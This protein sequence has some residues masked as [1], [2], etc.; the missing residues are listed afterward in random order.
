MK[1]VLVSVAMCAYNGEKYLR[2]Q[3]DSILSQSYSPLQIIIVDDNSSDETRNILSLYSEEHSNIDIFFNDSNLGY[4]K[5]F[6][7]AISKAEGEFIAIS[8]QD[9]IWLHDKVATLVESIGDNW[10]IF[11]NSQFIDSDDRLLNESLLPFFAFRSDYRG[12]LLENFVTGHTALLSKKILAYILPIPE[13]GFYDWWIGFIAMYH[14]KIAFSNQILTH[15]R[16]HNDS[17][18]Q[19][20]LSDNDKKINPKKNLSIQLAA[21]LKYKNL[22]AADRKFIGNLKKSIDSE[23]S[24]VFKSLFPLLLRD[25]STYFPKK[26]T[27][28][29]LSKLNFLLKFLRTYGIAGYYLVDSL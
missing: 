5:N 10:L 18:I 11:S 26:K 19:L 24:P 9:D 13:S 2:K 14:H 15:Y 7:M 23:L 22:K 4:N 16:I 3:L 27:K 29:M 21:F 6:E 17:V 20:A 1:N 25:F 12:I 8:D 28:S